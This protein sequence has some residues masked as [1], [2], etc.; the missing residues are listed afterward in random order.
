[1]KAENEFGIDQAHADFYQQGKDIPGAGAQ[2]H[3]FVKAKPGMKVTFRTSSA[4]EPQS[5]TYTVPESGWT[6][7]PMFGP[8]S[9]YYPKEG[10]RGPWIVQ[11]DG[12]DVM[13][14]IGLPEGKHVSTYIVTAND[15]GETPPLPGTPTPPELT[16]GEWKRER[17]TVTLA[18]NT[19]IVWEAMV[20]RA[21]K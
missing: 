1:M 6:N 11:V 3:I 7:H 19:T 12:I 14:G 8:G 17:I 15:R 16:P 2:N 10:Q 20:R 13:D 21:A 4:T 9:V 5:V 18:D